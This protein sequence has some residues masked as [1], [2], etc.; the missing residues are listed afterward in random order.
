MPNDANLLPWVKEGVFLLNVLTGKPL[1][2][3]EIWNQFTISLL[4][5]IKKTHWRNSCLEGKNQK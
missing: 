3:M 1:S 2:H 4:N 5:Y